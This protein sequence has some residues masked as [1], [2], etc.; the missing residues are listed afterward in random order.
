MPAERMPAAEPSLLAGPL[1][2]LTRGVLR[3][4]VAV[5]TVAIALALVALMLTGSRLGF[6][7]SRLDLLDPQCTHNR[8]WIDYIK[9]FG[10]QDDVVVVVQGSG[11]R[12]VVPVLEQLSSEL[13]HENHLFH[14]VLHQVNLS[15]IR[16]KGLYYLDPR[17]L[18]PIAPFLAEVRPIVDGQWSRLNVSNMLDAMCL[19]LH[20]SRLDY[21]REATLATM[22]RHTGC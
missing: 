20:D 22:D 16:S 2:W 1:A 18:Q 17:Q 6:H 21:R 7:T 4:P 12:Q 13:V 8:L 15:K 10:H 3:Y 5:I 11:R 19:Q 9:E 14:A